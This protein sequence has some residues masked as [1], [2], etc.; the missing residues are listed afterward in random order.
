MTR[1][2]AVEST[3]VP[4]A[5]GPYSVAVISQ[6][7]AFLSGQGPYDERGVLVGE[8]IE[9]QTRQ[10]LQNLEVVAKASGAS[11]REAVRVG[12]Y[13]TDMANFTGMNAV[14][15]EFFEQPYPARTTV[16]TGLPK[17]E[18]LVEIDVI[19]VLPQVT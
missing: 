9:S 4:A 18:M 11:L 15:A 8:E 14:F 7:F 2:Q 10:T 1:R 16:Q 5:S 19:V 13:L 12:V 3:K 17:P 6:G